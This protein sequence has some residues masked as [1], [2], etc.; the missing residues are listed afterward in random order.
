[1]SERTAS[2]AMPPLP[3]QWVMRNLGAKPVSGWSIDPFGHSSAM[4]YINKRAGMGGM[5]GDAPKGRGRL[6]PASF[7]QP[8]ALLSLFRHPQ[9]IQRIHYEV[10]RMLAK[11]KSLEFRWTQDWGASRRSVSL[12]F[13]PCP[14]AAPLAFGF[15]QQGTSR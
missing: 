4:A 5:V 14:L 8:T 11:K 1:M 12:A 9:V 3:L 15:P 6:F 13:F 7:L 2:D 10:K